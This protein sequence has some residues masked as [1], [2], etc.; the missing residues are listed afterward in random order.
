MI[1]SMAEKMNRFSKPVQSTSA[2]SLGGQALSPSF[3]LSLPTLINQLPGSLEWGVLFRTKALLELISSDQLGSMF[4]FPSDTDISSSVCVALTSAGKCLAFDAEGPWIWSLGEPQSDTAPGLAGRLTHKLTMLPTVEDAVCVGFGQL[5]GLSPVAMALTIK[6]GVAT[7]EAL[8]EQRPPEDHYDLLAAV[9]VR[10]LGGEWRNGH[11]CARF[12]NRL[13]DHLLAGMLANFA[14]TAHCNLFFLN[15]GRINAPLEAGLLNAA[16]ARVEHGFSKAVATAIGL[17]LAAR[18]SELAMTCIPPAPQPSYAFGDLVPLG[19]LTYALRSISTPLPAVEA[20]IVLSSRYL[21]RHRIGD[22]WPFHHGRLPTATDSAL[23]LLGQK[24]AQRID[25]LERFADGSG[26]YLPQLS[27]AE[28]GELHMRADAA[29]Q[30]WCQTDFA[31]TCLIRALRRSVSLGQLTSTV[32]LEAWFE[33]R[34]ALFFANPY[35]VD[36]TLSVAVAEDNTAMGL[37]HRLT[38]EILASANDDGSFGR[39][40]QPLSTALAIV[41]LASLGHR[42]RTI[43]MAQLRLLEALEPQGHGPAT[44]PFYAS[45]RLPGAA[46]AHVIRSGGMLSVDGQWHAL[47]LYEDT[48]RMVLNAFAILALQAPCDTR[49]R[50]TMAEPK[51]H[52]RYLATSA[53]RYVEAFALPPYLGSQP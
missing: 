30:H 42:S 48:H 17:V 36:W 23:I 29:V 7:A 40:D 13:G 50:G 14:R 1:A 21:D 47:S 35:L 4:G 51:C 2:P 43:R 18:R 44:T 31:T 8:F 25:A 52:P 41:A 28:G 15:H 24:D 46:T 12:N 22:F 6:E 53:A 32:W 16:S 49:E 33:R 34:A 9:G 26:G 5:P 45:G 27:N 11:W 3:G 37:R 38:A 39:F 20:A 10:F 19:I